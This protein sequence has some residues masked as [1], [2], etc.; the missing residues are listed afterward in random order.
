MHRILLLLSVTV[1]STVFLANTVWVQDAEAAVVTI[2]GESASL[3]GKVVRL[4]TDSTA[5]GGKAVFF[6]SNGRATMQVSG[7][8]TRLEVSVRGRQCSGSPTV[9]VLVDGVRV[10]RKSVPNTS[11]ATYGVA[12]Q[13]GEGAHTVEVRYPNNYSNRTCD[14]DLIFDKMAV[15]Q[16]DLL[17][18]PAADYEFALIGNDGAHLAEERAAG[19]ESKVV[20]LSWRKFYPSEGQKDRA[21]VDRKKHE[22][23]GLRAAGFR[24]ILSLGYHD[25]PPWVHQNYEDSYY[26][27]QHGERW[28]GDTFSSD[29]TPM[30]N[31]DA[32][33]VFN[34][35]LRGL[36]SS[37][38][39][40][41]LSELGTDFYAVRLG[42]GRYGEL[43][44]PPAHW[45]GKT[46]RYWA[47]DRNAQASC[48]TPL[49]RPAEPSP[50]G[51]AERFLDWYLG[52]L[53]GYQNWQVEALR[54][55]GYPGRIMMLYP[56]WGIRP[57]QLEAAVASGLDGSTPAER[58]GEV[59]RGYDFARQVGSIAD[60]KVVVT[61]TWLDASVD[62]LADDRADMRYWS[63]VH[64]LSYLADSHPLSLETYGENT[65][66]GSKEQMEYSARQMRRWGLS[67]MAWYKESEMFSGSYAT[68]DDYA[69]IIVLSSTR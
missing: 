10:L 46:N 42:G 19:I 63:P 28:T 48:P 41:A 61:T 65:G 33:L 67:G 35:Q 15:S 11:Y 2:E 57:G 32:N 68:L 37:Y 59:Q 44:Y 43:T 39:K 64:Y 24:V 62:P 52:A 4:N 9:D 54:G 17:V 20:A 16:P 58:N 25:T 47:Y 3:S 13:K 38:M 69:A 23:Q 22:I 31:G 45:N 36:V 26:V 53:A 66:R 30:D 49:W 27:D 29:G 50:G 14:R 21:Y 12:L 6:V 1:A 8:I 60:P 7:A 55:A 5:S 51:E 40:D 18:E 56:S 34:P